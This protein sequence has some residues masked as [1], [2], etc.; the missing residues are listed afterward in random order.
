MGGRAIRFPA[1][2]FGMASHIDG[3]FSSYFDLVGGFVLSWGE[4]PSRP[5]DIEQ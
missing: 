3:I 1:P 5:T 2:E 4:I